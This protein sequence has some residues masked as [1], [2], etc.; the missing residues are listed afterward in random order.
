MKIL[1]LLIVVTFPLNYFGQLPN[2]IPQDSLKV[3]YNFVGNANDYFGNNNGVVNG[4]SLVSN[5]YLN[6]NSAYSFNGINNSIKIPTEFVNGQT[7]YSNSIRIKFYLNQAGNYGLWN[8]D[9]S[10]KE[11][12]IQS[13]SDNSIGL[14]WAYPS[15]YKSIRTNAN[16]I[17]SN[18]WYDV[19]IVIDN[20]IGHIYINGQLQTSYQTNTV[21]SS[22]I[23]YS[24]SGSC[25]TSYGNNRFGFVKTSCS[26]TG[27][28][29]GKI[30]EFGLWN[31][32]LTQCEIKGL[33]NAQLSTNSSVSITACDSYSW[34]QNGTTYL[35]SGTYKDTVTNT[36]GCDSII[37]LNLTINNSTASSV[38]VT[39]CDSY[40]WIQ[41]GTTYL[42]SGTYKDTVTNTA[43]CDS[44][45]SLNLTINPGVVITT[46][47]TN[48]YVTVGNN[49][50]FQVTATGS[51][52]NY[53]WQE[54]NGTGFL[55]LSNLG[56]YS[57]VNTNILNITGVNASIQQF[58]YRCIITNSNGCVDTTVL[59]ILNISLTGINENSLSTYFTV[60][61]NP[62]NEIL[63][64]NTNVTFSAIRI[65]NAVGK[66]VFE[67]DENNT[68]D[69][70]SLKAGSYFIQL[71]GTEKQILTTEK[72]IKK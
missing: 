4:A 10:W 31:R 13:F 52:L 5:Q 37:S 43:G 2:Y 42:A 28:L 54:N 29:N 63:T 30:D 49:A 39:S 12:A 8:K 53:Q 46:Q 18:T 60:Y 66:L 56:V 9:G 1:L 67:A 16:T 27:Y 38:A 48:Q 61:P 6:P 47:P 62:T 3:Y 34:T 23:S 64:L 20:N 51:S 33:Y 19:I 59:A 41:N 22:S 21:T 58:G 68:L 36:A 70:S 71:I 45:I 32:A 26:P 25:G 24:H 35:A 50:Q 69:V 57:G 17:M 14:F 55:N 72:F 40:S 11:V 44:I 7:L 15:S 65:T